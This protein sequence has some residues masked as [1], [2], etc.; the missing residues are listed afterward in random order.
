MTET[1]RR[2]PRMLEALLSRILD[3]RDRDWI[4]GDLREE[5]ARVAAAYGR[6]RARTWYLRQL[7]RSVIPSARRRMITRGPGHQPPIRRSG[8][9][10]FGL[11]AR[12]ILR[13]LV[14]TP[15][16]TAGSI[17]T[18]G[19]ELGLATAIFSVVNGVLLRPLPYR[20]AERLLWIWSDLTEIGVPR[21]LPILNPT[22]PA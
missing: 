22:S 19:L 14:R 12:L 21:V 2:P 20:D 3:G 17:L 15:L 8:A 18:L 11:H 7:V 13:Q 1:D 9:R 16:F 6:R 5:H 4:L 10:S